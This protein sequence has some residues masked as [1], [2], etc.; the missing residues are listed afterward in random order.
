MNNNMSSTSNINNM[1]ITTPAITGLGITGK[2]MVSVNVNP[3]LV[4]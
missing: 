2:V 4:I 1:N 3:K